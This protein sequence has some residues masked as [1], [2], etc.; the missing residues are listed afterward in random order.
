MMSKIGTALFI[1]LL[2]VAVVLRYGGRFPGGT[3]RACSLSHALVPFQQ[4]AQKRTETNYVPAP[5]TIK[6]L[7]IMIELVELKFGSLLRSL[8]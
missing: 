7:R 6:D 4:N 1:C 3:G 2:I 8:Y 5:S